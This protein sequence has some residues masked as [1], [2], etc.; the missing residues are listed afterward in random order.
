MQYYSY[1]LQIR[2]LKSI[3]INNF[4]RLFQQ[5]AVDMY[6]KI[7]SSRLSYISTEKGQIKIRS[8][9]YKNV[10]DAFNSCKSDLSN[11]GKYHIFKKR[12]KDYTSFYI[13]WE[14]KTYE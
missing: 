9:M 11:L 14:S 7:E 5:Y 8:E 3:T 13:Y 10:Q 1:V 4:G 2:D 6:K 12:K